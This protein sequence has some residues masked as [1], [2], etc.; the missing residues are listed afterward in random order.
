MADH[1]N[2]VRE[3]EEKDDAPEDNK[4]FTQ[5]MDTFRKDFFITKREH[6]SDFLTLGQFKEMFQDKTSWASL[7][8]DIHV[9]VD[10]KEQEELFAALDQDCDGYVAWND[11]TAVMTEIQAPLSCKHVF[12]LHGVAK[13]ALLKLKRENAIAIS[14]KKPPSSVCENEIAVAEGRMDKLEEKVDEFESMLK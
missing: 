1:M 14:H 2:K 5:Q 13:Q 10:Q 3:D 12:E 7:L 8:K 6:D 9:N 11:I 4:H